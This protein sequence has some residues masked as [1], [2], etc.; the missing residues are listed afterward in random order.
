M[1][2]CASSEAEHTQAAGESE[3]QL[4]IQTDA[5]QRQGFTATAYGLETTGELLK[6]L[7][8]Q[9]ELPESLWMELTLEFCDVTVPHDCVLQEAGVRE[10]SEYDHASGVETDVRC[11]C[12]GSDREGAGH[13]AGPTDPH[14]R[15]HQSSRGVLV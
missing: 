4:E 7:A 12:T 9:L 15:R 3:I 8:P 1:G 13:R 5:S 2:V 14:R 10:V 11:G 6:R